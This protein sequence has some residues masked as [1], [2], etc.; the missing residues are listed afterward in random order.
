MSDP[1]AT[2]TSPRPGCALLALPVL[3]TVVMVAAYA[4]LA[5][6]GYVGRPADGPVQTIQFEGC[7]DAGAVVLARARLMGLGD[8]K[9]APTP[10]GFSLT[11]QMP[12]DEGVTRGIPPT[13][14]IPGHVSLADAVTGE[15]LLGDD[16]VDGAFPHMQLSGIPVTRLLLTDGAVTYLRKMAGVEP[17]RRVVVIIDGVR[18]HEADVAH[19]PTNGELD[20]EVDADTRASQ[21]EV[22]AARAIA[23]GEGPL[24][25]E[26]RVIP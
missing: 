21:L 25:C 16:A 1:T 20:L 8:P 22:A 11:A 4:A 12:A 17:T 5:V 3:M 18:V 6:F 19:Y 9:L 23:L 10:A 2:R 13:L 14:V 7:A 26:I 15:E 24:P